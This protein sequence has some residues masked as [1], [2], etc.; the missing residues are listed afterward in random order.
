MKQEAS[1]FQPKVAQ[2]K[3]EEIEKGFSRNEASRRE[4]IASFEYAKDG[5]T[6]KNTFKPGWQ[7]NRVKYKPHEWW[8][9]VGKS[10]SKK[11]MLRQCVS[12]IL[13]GLPGY[14]AYNWWGHAL[15]LVGLNW[16]ESL[17]NNVAWVLRNSHDEN[18]VIE[19]TGSRGVPDE[20]YG[21]RAVS[22]PL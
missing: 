11:G 16:D 1:W 10:F 9:T 17:Q 7:A 2:S 8:D 14:I 6:N 15:E 22:L 4:G 13:N 19:L 18:D 12:L 3:F 21:V 5:T 20:A